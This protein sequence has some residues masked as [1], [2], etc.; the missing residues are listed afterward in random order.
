MGIQNEPKVR[1]WRR[2]MKIRGVTAAGLFLLLTLPNIGCGSN[3]SSG[4]AISQDQALSA[5]TDIFTAMSDAVTATGSG[6]IRTPATQEAEANHI[7]STN[8]AETPIVPSIAGANLL[9]TSRVESPKTT[10]PSY[11]YHCPSGGT[12]VVNGSYTGTATSASVTIVETI[13]SCADNGLTMNGNPNVSVSDILTTSGN[14][15]TD[16][17]T[18]NGG[19]TVGSN[20]C[21][22]N[23][24]IS[25]T[26][27]DVT[28]A[29]S[30][31]MSGSVCGVSVNGTL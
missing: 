31:T 19:F 1:V 25:A 11:T 9:A 20:S 4:S 28:Y 18:M 13:K 6:L 12:I 30:G 17:M 29:E 15:I 14:I 5:T 21:S 8:L 26:V 2:S 7:R 27:N 22:I 10:L 3:N 24:T 23:V 16:V